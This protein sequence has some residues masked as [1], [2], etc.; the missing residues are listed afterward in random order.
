M[1]TAWLCLTI[2]T[3]VSRTSSSHTIP[4]FLQQRLVV[5]RLCRIPIVRYKY[6]SLSNI[7]SDFRFISS[8]TAFFFKVRNGQ[9]FQSS[10]RM[11][12]IWKFV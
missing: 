9:V 2:V 6:F 10:L 4:R 12:K 5:S 8:E 7:I 1:V 3:I 11:W